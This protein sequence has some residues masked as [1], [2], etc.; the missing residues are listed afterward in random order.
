MKHEYG[1]ERRRLFIQGA[2]EVELDAPEHDICT[3]R[4]NAQVSICREDELLT[5]LQQL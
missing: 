5:Q 1:V 4:R 2:N 3:C